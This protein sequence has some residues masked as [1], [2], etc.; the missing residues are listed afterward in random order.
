M[1]RHRSNEV[2]PLSEHRATPSPHEKGT[3]MSFWAYS[4]GAIF[5]VSIIALIL[6]ACG[7]VSL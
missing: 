4:A 7:V 3:A 5:L 1:G 2:K 6:E